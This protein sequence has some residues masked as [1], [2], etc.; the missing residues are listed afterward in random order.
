MKQFFVNSGPHV[1]S[2]IT[3]RRIMFDVCIALLPSLVMG[4]VYFGGPAAFTVAIA[5]VGALL[6]EF[7]YKLCQRKKVSQIIAEFDFTSL[8][9][10]LILGLILPPLDYSHWYIPLLSSI[11]A[12][13]AV[14]MIFG[15]TGKNIVNPAVTGRIFAFIAFL[16]VVSSYFP[17][18]EINTLNNTIVAGATPLTQFLKNG[19]DMQAV[20]ITNVDL[21]LGT[22]LAGSIGETCKVAILVGYIYL[23]VRKVI[24]WQYPLIY[25]GVTGLI[26]VFCA[27]CDFNVFLPSILSGGL[28]F[29]AVFMA[30]DYVTSPVGTLAQYVYYVILGVI[31]GLLRFGTSIE[32]VSFAILLGNLIV[33]LLSIYLKPRHFGEKK[34][35]EIIKEKLP[36]KKEGK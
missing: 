19:F 33:P 28:L 10:G 2:S 26:S 9:T 3:T 25:V 32:V 21:L 14:K 23:S 31:T 7:C 22:G 29:G 1:R 27:K 35:F 13:I 11:F 12:I 20:G 24:K 4:L 18:P 36:K 8:I 15:G 5:V 17:N 16:S 34:I 6:S 30:T